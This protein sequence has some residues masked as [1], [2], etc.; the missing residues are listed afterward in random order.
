MEDFIDR[1]LNVLGRVVRNSELHPHWQLSSDSRQCLP[2]VTNHFQRVGRGKHPDA[3]ERRGLSVEAD[4]RFVVLGAEH[5]IGNFAE[6]YHD[7]ILLFDHK[8]AKFI[9]RAQ[10]GV[11]N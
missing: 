9:R 8:L 10:I 1:I 5:Y 2:N 4:I 7:T 6:P 3:H 11:G